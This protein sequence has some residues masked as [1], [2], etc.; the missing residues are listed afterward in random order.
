MLFRSYNEV[1]DRFN[2]NNIRGHSHSQELLISPPLL[3]QIKLSASACVLIRAGM[4]SVENR[5]DLDAVSS[6]YPDS[7]NIH[8]V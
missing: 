6:E 2:T 4:Q 8:S 5:A 7:S 3:K 1:L